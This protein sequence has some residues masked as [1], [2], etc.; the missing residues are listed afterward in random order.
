M[1]CVPEAKHSFCNSVFESER[2]QK[3]IRFLILIMHL[4][5]TAHTLPA[6]KQMCCG[7]CQLLHYNVTAQ[8]ISSIDSLR[9]SLIINLSILHLCRRMTHDRMHLYVTALVP[10]RFLQPTK[11]FVANQ[12]V[13]LEVRN[14]L[15]LTSN[16]MLTV[17]R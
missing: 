9:R 17:V 13:T 3:Q 15:L 11:A 16:G 1:I 4:E 8:T 2:T 12:E 10:L 6:I 14:L 5:H 7:C